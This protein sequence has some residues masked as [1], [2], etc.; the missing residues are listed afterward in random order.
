MKI[1]LMPLASKIKSREGNLGNRRHG[2]ISRRELTLPLLVFAVGCERGLH[3]YAM[4]FVDSQSARRVSLPVT[5]SVFAFDE[6]GR[7]DVSQAA[8]SNHHNQPSASTA[9]VAR[10]TTGIN[11]QTERPRARSGPATTA[12]ARATA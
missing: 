10:L 9:N 4:Q 2:Q 7:R 6:F 12:S 11:G 5:T 3:Y 8:E 1:L